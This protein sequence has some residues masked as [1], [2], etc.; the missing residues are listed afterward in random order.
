M[1]PHKAK[2]MFQQ[3]G[4]VTRI[5]LSEEDNLQRIKR[6]EHGGNGAKQFTEGWVEFA[7][8][9]VAKNVAESLNNTLIGGKKGSFYHDDIWNLKYLKGFK[10]D[11]LTEK[12]AYEKRVKEM[13]LRAAM[14]EAKRSN[15]E[16]VEQFE[17]NRVQQHIAERK[18]RKA[19]PSVTGAGDNDSSGS[20]SELKRKFRQKKVIANSY[21]ERQHKAKPAL[22]AKVFSSKH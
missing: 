3:Y 13:K 18:K 2:N 19:D 5:Y 22:L 4:E 14:L 16:I 15:A 6:K 9:K 12:M 10:W 17:K 11:Y 21:G 8:K 1:K 7:D 20:R